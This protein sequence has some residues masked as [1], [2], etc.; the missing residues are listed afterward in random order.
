MTLP[1][2]TPPN[3]NSAAHRPARPHGAVTIQTIYGSEKSKIN[4][5]LD[6]IRFFRMLHRFKAIKKKAL[7]P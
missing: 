2:A 3:P 6:T 7:A 1:S 4:P 5:F